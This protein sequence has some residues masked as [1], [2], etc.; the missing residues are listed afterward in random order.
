[1]PGINV[2][3]ASGYTD[4]T[5]LQYGIMEA[6]AHFIQKPFSPAGLAHKVREVLDRNRDPS[7]TLDHAGPTHLRSAGP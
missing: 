7:I 3:F 6:G 2:V 4:D 5:I 1:L